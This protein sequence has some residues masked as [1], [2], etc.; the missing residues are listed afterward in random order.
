[1]MFPVSSEAKQATTDCEKG[2]SCLEGKRKD[3]CEVESCIGQKVH[4]IKRLNEGNCSYQHSFGEQNF[5][6]CPIRKEIF[7]KYKI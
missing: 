5:C 3:L 2:V 7:N 1:M 4:F 6:S